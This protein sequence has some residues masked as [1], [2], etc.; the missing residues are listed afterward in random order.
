MNTLVVYDSQYGN[1]ER[2]A[3]A[4]AE[5][6]HG[7]GQARAVRIDPS[8]RLDLDRIDMLIFGC[9]TQAWNTTAAMQAWLKALDP[10][11][12]HGVALAC[13]DTRFNKPGWLTGSAARV[14][15]NT[16]K[17]KGLTPAVPPQSF[18]VDGGEGPLQEGELQR[19]AAWA[20]TLASI[21]QA[22]SV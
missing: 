13:F 19:A 21:G 22:V 17:H 16:L 11:R 9:P 8:Y 10:E 3:Q 5:A 6:L 4:I 2:I 7:L 15:V 18:F 12:L 20:R 1:T 14:M